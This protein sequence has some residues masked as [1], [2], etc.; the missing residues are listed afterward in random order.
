MRRKGGSLKW[1]GGATVGLELSFFPAPEG[2]GF[3]RSERVELP[4]DS[5]RGGRRGSVFVVAVHDR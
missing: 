1:G 2:L 3:I 5:V 4:I